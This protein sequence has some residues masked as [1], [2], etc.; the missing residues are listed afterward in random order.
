MPCGKE[1]TTMK[2][3]IKKSIAAAILGAGVLLIS[4]K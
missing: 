3:K 1:E 2:T 4:I